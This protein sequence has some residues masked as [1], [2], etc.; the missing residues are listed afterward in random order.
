MILVNLFILIKYLKMNIIKNTITRLRLFKTIKY[1]LYYS[2]FL[3]TFNLKRNFINAINQQI[4][5]NEQPNDKEKILNSLINDCKASTSEEAL[6]LNIISL[7]K[8]FEEKRFNDIINNK[9]IDKH[10]SLESALFSYL[11][12]SS[13]LHMNLFTHNNSTI[14]NLLPE[15]NSMELPSDLKSFLI[16]DDLLDEAYKKLYFEKSLVEGMNYFI[17]VIKI[18]NNKPDY[19]YSLTIETK[20]YF[21][22]SKIFKI[23]NQPFYSL[24]LIEKCIS[25]NANNK[26]LLSNNESSINKYIH[27]SLYS[28]VIIDYYIITE[29][30]PFDTRTI[31]NIFTSINSTIKDFITDNSSLVIMSLYS[32]LTFKSFETSELIKNNKHMNEIFKQFNF[33]LSDKNYNSLVAFESSKVVDNYDNLYLKLIL[34]LKLDLISILTANNTKKTKLLNNLFLK[35]IHNFTNNIKSL[36]E[37]LGFKSQLKKY[38]SKDKDE[39][40]ASIEQNNI[41]KG[42]L[43][44]Y[45]SIF[46]YENAVFC[47]Y[48][49]HELLSE[50]NF[51]LSAMFLEKMISLIN[52]ISKSQNCHNEINSFILQVAYCNLEYYIIQEQLSNINKTYI[53][54]YKIHKEYFNKNSIFGK[55]LLDKTQCLMYFHNFG[56]ITNRV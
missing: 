11:N 33:K 24:L 26:H 43:D 46:E 53:T 4:A 22:L 37:S 29:L 42:Y 25:I 35:A 50:G 18:F 51:K 19:A 40:E 3:Y 8:K 28:S 10:N 14:R 30:I 38:N 5:E 32:K 48:V 39:K 21:Y 17:C 2:T 12:K 41:I 56:M 45:N 13:F 9:S 49:F 36:E 54:Y 7:F 52:Q 31:K 16:I 23:L 15:L 27:R 34:Q 55:E 44:S 47:D 1:N 6:S 20:C